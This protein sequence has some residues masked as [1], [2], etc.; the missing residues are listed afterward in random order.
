MAA[1]DHR[2]HLRGDRGHEGECDM[3][4]MC[5]IDLLGTRRASLRS[6]AGVHDGRESSPEGIFSARAAVIAPGL[7]GRLRRRACLDRA[8]NSQLSLA[9]AGL[10]LDIDC[11]GI[12]LD[13]ARDHGR[14]LFTHL[15]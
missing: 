10:D 15:L 8:R 12:D 7:A 11:F 6:I 2:V 3:C 13:V 9:I 4:A 5:A 14:D 1:L